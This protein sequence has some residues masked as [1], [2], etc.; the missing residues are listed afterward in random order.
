M[1]R[2]MLSGQLHEGQTV[3][4]DVDASGDGLAITD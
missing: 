1:A 4:F 2:A 3:T